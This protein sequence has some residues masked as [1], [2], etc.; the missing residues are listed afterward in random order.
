MTVEIVKD[1][2]VQEFVELVQ[3]DSETKHEQEISRVLKEKFNALGLEVVEDDSRE[4]TGHGSGN[5]IVTWKAE[6]VEQAPKIFFTCHM[7]T[8]TP[9]KG[10]KPQLGED[11]WIRSDGSTILGADD[12]AGIAALF[13]AIRVV[14]EQNIPHGQIQFV[15]TAGEES[16]LMGARAMKPEVLDSDFGYALDSNGEVGSICIAAPTQARIEMR[17]TGK[18]AHAGV[19]P[20][21]GISAIQ[22]ASK[23]ISKM[24]LGRIDKETTANIGSFEGGGA[25]NVVCDFVLIRAE[26]RSIVQEKVNHQIQHMR[27]ALETTT[28]EFGAQG[29]FRSEV[30]YPAF[31]FT[32]HDEVVQVAQRAIQGLGMATSTFHSGGGS[33]ANVFNGLGIPTVNLAVGYQNIHTTEEKIKADDLVKVAEVV[34]ALIQET[35]K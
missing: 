20:E 7:D 16:G 13:E 10:I 23:A 32:E 18:S 5:L 33:D 27:E 29:E 15:I 19:N 30:I 26:A 22:V 4:R 21:D 31:S 8:V 28:R 14:R 2:I 6:G 34:V 25:T 12:K 17:I 35:T 1:R 24:K 11:G 9:G 3:V